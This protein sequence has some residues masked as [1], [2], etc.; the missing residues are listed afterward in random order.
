MQ[1]L[2]SDSQLFFE[3]KTNECD[4]PYIPEVYLVGIVAPSLVGV[5]R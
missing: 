2:E 4:T 3:G 5:Y 1:I